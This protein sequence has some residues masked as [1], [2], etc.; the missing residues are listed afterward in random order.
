MTPIPYW[1]MASIY[2]HIQSCKSKA[3]LV[4][5]LACVKQ[6]VE[7][8]AIC[9]VTHK[10]ILLTHPLTFT[11]I[12]GHS[13]TMHWQINDTKAVVYIFLSL[14]V[15]GNAVWF[16]TIHLKNRKSSEWSRTRLHSP[17]QGVFYHSIAWTQQSVI[18]V[19][20]ST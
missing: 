9:H 20:R 5:S 6:D 4:W 18:F 12:K 16:E 1:I 2:A 7:S 10:M 17:Q 3:K 19:L 15:E 11:H 14:I 8:G 13:K